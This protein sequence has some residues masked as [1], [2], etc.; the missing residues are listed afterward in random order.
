[1]PRSPLLRRPRT[2]VVTA[3]VLGALVL[4]VLPAVAA[5]VPSV[6]G[7]APSP[8]HIGRT[9]TVTGS[10]L[11]GAT[12]VTLGSIA[13]AFSPVDDGH[14]TA[15]IPDGAATAPVTVTN[16]A[17][18]ATSPAPLE[19]APAPAA[20]TDLR[21]RVGD[22]VL[23]LS[24]TGGGT[25]G[26]LVREVT[27]V[28]A[29]LST[30]SGRGVPA[31]GSS[32]RDTAFTNRAQ[33]SYAVWAVDSDGTTSG[34][35]TTLVV[36]P[37][38]AVPTSLAASV[39]TTRVDAGRSVTLSGR[40]T[41]GTDQ[42]AAGQEPVDV[43]TT[44]GGS[45]TAARV[46]Q[47]RTGADGTVSWTAAP[48]GTAAYQLRFPGD[49]FSAASSSAAL[50]VAVQPRISAALYP[51]AVV[52]GQTAHLRG[53][54]TP[55]YGGVRAQ[56][57]RRMSDGTW[58][59]ISTVG[60][61]GTGAYDAG[62]T[63]PVG[64]YVL[65]VLVPGTPGYLSAASGAVTLSVG[66]RTLVQGDRGGDVVVLE[67][68]LAGL[69]YDV[70]RQDGVFDYDLRHAVLTFQK[71]ERLARTSS[72]GNAERSRIDHPTAFRVRYP[73]SRRSFE[74]DI[75]R[76]VLVMSTGGVV[77]RI[78]DVSTGSDKLY[79]VDGVTDR[80]TTP[81]GRFTIIRK[82]DGI[83]VSRLGELYRPSYFFQGWAIH[84]NGSVPA[85]PASHGCVRITDPAAD[86][87]FALLSVGSPVAV[88]DE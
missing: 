60:V 42:V 85:F 23:V 37:V 2:L 86:R 66:Q 47:L 8:T 79:T 75:T 70:G 10:G 32:A 81:R 62:F 38:P 6:S 73:N 17:G 57:Q 74:V 87:L 80:A 43:F 14:L 61:S 49:A 7:V 3:G 48:R 65:R 26:A 15:T 27:G 58:R 55:N 5:T 41:R 12:A 71:V 24:W 68:R 52:R 9:V 25:A 50:T 63:P 64:S 16:D 11:T 51:A 84:G 19:V 35:P 59:A 33:A 21:A 1:M 18:S 88:Y 4:P 31:T 30:T 83:R 77:Q 44:P 13:M 36:D 46:A 54:L 20:V 72:W 22:R 78:L 29:P 69:H 34:Q 67:R 28:P 76:Q 56:V 45:A 39:S 40:L 82:I 53:T